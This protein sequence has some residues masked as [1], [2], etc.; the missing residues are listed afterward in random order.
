MVRGGF[1]GGKLLELLGLEEEDVRPQPAPSPRPDRRPPPRE[2]AVRGE[3]PHGEG[4]AQPPAPPQQAPAPGAQER[5]SN[6]PRRRRPIDFG[7][8]SS[9]DLVRSFVMSEI[10]GPPPGKRR[11]RR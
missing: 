2:D 6:E 4:A 9:D 8:L 1:D 7:T 11:R 5:P 3:H 10:F